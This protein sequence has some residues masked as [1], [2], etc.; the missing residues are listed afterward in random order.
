M[1]ERED[2]STEAAVLGVQP[3]DLLLL[4]PLNSVNSSQQSQLLRA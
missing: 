3:V 2:G 1:I 4:V